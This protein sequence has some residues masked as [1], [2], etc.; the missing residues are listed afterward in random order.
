MTSY[1]IQEILTVLHELSCR[2]EEDRDLIPALKEDRKQH[3]EELRYI[4]LGNYVGFPAG[5]DS[6]EYHYYPA[7]KSR[8]EIVS[9]SDRGGAL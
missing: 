4:V 8:A 1:E 3:L 6:L 7:W 2:I 5:R 9:D